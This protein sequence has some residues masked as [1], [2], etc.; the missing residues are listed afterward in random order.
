MDAYWPLISSARW[1]SGKSR[2][3]RPARHVALDWYTAPGAEVG[4][5]SELVEVVYAD[6]GTEWYQLPISYRATPGEGVLAETSEGFAHDATADPEAMTAVLRAIQTGHQGMDV[7]CHSTGADALPA[8]PGRRY[9]GEQS[10]TSVFFG[11]SA[12]LK[13]FRKLEPG[14]N[15]DIELHAALAG[16]PAVAR[17]YGWIETDEWDLA[18]LVESLPDPLDGYVLA[19]ESVTADFTDQAAALGDALASVHAMLRDRLG[20]SAGD[21]DQL[22]DQFV[23]RARAVAKDAPPLAEWLPALVQRY[24]TLRGHEFA[25]QR[26]HGDFHLGQTLL[27][28]GGWRIVDFEG[29]PMKTMAERRAMDSP[30]R[31]VAGMLRSI[32]YAAA[33]DPHARHL[34]WRRCAREAFLNS[35]CVA[36]GVDASPVLAAYELDKAVYEVRYEVRNRPHL[37][38]VPLD[39]ITTTLQEA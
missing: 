19:C 27:T 6:G 17:L 33:S 34:D 2:G 8:E 31:D 29:E 7:R 1:Y 28:P 30:W 10:N 3:G 36:M 18:M 21:G 25:T 23:A 15:L 12:M 37:I 4:V 9:G 20:S 32:D 14:K 5:R 24:D 35:Y 26:V 11:R 38:G 13:F 22:A 16:S 39:F